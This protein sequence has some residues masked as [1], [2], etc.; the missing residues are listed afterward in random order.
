MKET[1]NRRRTGLDDLKRTSNNPLGGVDLATLICVDEIGHSFDL[2]IVFVPNCARSKSEPEAVIGW[3]THGLV[4][5]LSKGL[6]SLPVSIFASTR[7][8]RT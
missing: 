2:W 7:Y 6:T 5:W 1:I 4:S 3:K 8:L